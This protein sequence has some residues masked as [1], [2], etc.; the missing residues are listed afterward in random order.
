MARGLKRRLSEVARRTR[1][2]F[3]WHLARNEGAAWRPDDPVGPPVEHGV[4]Q[5][6]EEWKQA[7]S[8]CRDAGLPLH[9]DLPKNWDSLIALRY[10]LSETDPGA[11]VVDAGAASYSRIL[12][13]L[14]LYGYRDLLGIGLDIEGRYRRGTIRYRSGDLTRTELADESVDAV[15]CLSVIEHGVSEEE[16]FAECGRILR[17]GGLLFTSTDYWCEPVDTTGKTAY[18]VPVTIYSKSEVEELLDAGRSHGF[19]LAAPLDLDCGE[20]AVRWDRMELEYTF[21]CFGMR[22]VE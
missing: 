19:E 5:S 16:Y 15:T 13:W 4:L 7:V 11:R 22:K 8:T 9:S 20:R 6:E 21:L 12:P 3:R 18:G 2:G 14:F 10:I 1:I 17:S